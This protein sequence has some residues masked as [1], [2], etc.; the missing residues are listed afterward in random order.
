[1]HAVLPHSTCHCIFACETAEI[2]TSSWVLRGKEKVMMLMKQLLVQCYERTVL[3]DVQLGILRILTL[4]WLGWHFGLQL[5][6]I[7][8]YCLGLKDN[9]TGVNAFDLDDKLIM[10]DRTSDRLL[11]H[12][13]NFNL[14]FAIRYSR[15][16]RA[17]QWVKMFCTSCGLV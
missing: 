10:T 9:E 14:F 4:I 15:V 3:I 7:D 6:L 2:F 13:R 8:F 11:K 17:F 5:D 16:P 12:Y 1:M